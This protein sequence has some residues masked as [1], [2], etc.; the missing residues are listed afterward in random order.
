MLFSGQ[1][2]DRELGAIAAQANGLWVAQ[3]YAAGPVAAAIQAVPVPERARRRPDGSVELKGF[4]KEIVARDDLEQLVLRDAASDRG[5][6]D[7]DAV[8]ALI[9]A[10]R[11]GADHTTALV[12]LAGIESSGT[13]SSWTLSPLPG[14]RADHPRSTSTTTCPAPHHRR[15]DGVRPPCGR[16]L[17]RCRCA[18]RPCP[19]RT[20]IGP[21]AYGAGYS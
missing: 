7:P 2:A 17:R 19:R 1:L 4:F 13:G 6:F 20:E 21:G 15:R 10:H 14:D 12:M 11:A 9:R 8:D 5:V 18:R 16:G 3:P